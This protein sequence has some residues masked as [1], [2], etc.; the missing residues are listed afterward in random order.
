MSAG[1]RGRR[2]AHPHPTL[3]TQA[4]SLSP[5]LSP[6]P[7]RPS[8]TSGLISI[9]C[10]AMAAG[11]LRPRHDSVHRTQTPATVDAAARSRPPTCY[12]RAGWPTPRR[13]GGRGR[14]RA[15]PKRGGRGVRRCEPGRTGG[16]G[17]RCRESRGA[18]RARPALPG[19]GGTARP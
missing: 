19:V 1:E 16:C 10:Q 11:R 15:R 18:G 13:G 6:R 17:S 12:I 8:H 7:R 5:L 3:T 14:S 4:R 2:I 9:G